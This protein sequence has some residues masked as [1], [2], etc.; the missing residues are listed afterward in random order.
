M[1]IKKTALSL[2][3]I[4]GLSLSCV[5]QAQATGTGMVA[6]M[7]ITAGATISAVSHLN[8]TDIGFVDGLCLLSITTGAL[9]GILGLLDIEDKDKADI[10]EGIIGG[11]MLSAFI[12]P[13]VVI[14][15][16]LEQAAGK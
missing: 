5:P 14:G 8:F 10:K 1:N 6:S 15:Q 3:I 11:M 16:Q 12:A 13:F 4:A 2:A 9:V 7:L